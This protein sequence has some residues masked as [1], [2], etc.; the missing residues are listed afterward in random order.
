MVFVDVT[1]LMVGRLSPVFLELC[2]VNETVCFTNEAPCD[3]DAC[4]QS[5]HDLL[6]WARCVNHSHLTQI[7]PS[8]RMGLFSRLKAKSDKTVSV[9]GFR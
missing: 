5:D 2:V 1:K 8:T 3:V 9:N 7:L 4:M 6:R